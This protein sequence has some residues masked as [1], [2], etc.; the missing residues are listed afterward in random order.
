MEAILLE[1]RWISASVALLAVAVATGSEAQTSNVTLTTPDGMRATLVGE[2]GN[3]VIVVGSRQGEPTPGMTF[4]GLLTGY[5][6]TPTG[7]V[8]GDN[9]QG[10]NK[11][12]YDAK[13]G[14]NL[15]LR[16]YREYGGKQTW[17][18]FRVSPQVITGPYRSWSLV[19]DGAFGPKK[20][21]QYTLDVYN[22]IP[23][24]VEGCK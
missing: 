20:S 17:T 10:P 3:C 11:F 18:G 24:G 2:T 4:R 14:Q 7:D 15:E 19:T 12:R 1:R 5:Q 16:I 8:V 21:D 22:Y 6:S 23:S 13:T 9:A